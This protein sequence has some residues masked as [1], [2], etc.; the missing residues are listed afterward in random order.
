MKETWKEGPDEY[1]VL[2]CGAK[3]YV[4]GNRCGVVCMTCLMIVLPVGVIP[5][6]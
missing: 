2:P 4:D 5:G 6:I 1:M 3:G